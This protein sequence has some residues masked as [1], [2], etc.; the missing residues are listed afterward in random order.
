MDK[1][2]YESLRSKLD[3]EIFRLESSHPI[4]RPAEN[5][6]SVGMI[7]HPGMDVSKVPEDRI[8]LMHTMLHMLYQN[9]SGRGLT[10]KNI[11]E[12]H[13]EVVKRIPNHQ[14]FDGLDD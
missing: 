13:S 8:S 9:R 5:P 7:I 2:T 11:E 10:R 1:K 12:L 6:H 14:R 3:A 4:P